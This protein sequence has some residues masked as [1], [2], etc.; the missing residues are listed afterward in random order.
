MALLVFL[1]SDTRLRQ[2]SYTRRPHDDIYIYTQARGTRRAR[3]HRAA[4]TDVGRVLDEA[5][6][7]AQPLDRDA[8]RGHRALCAERRACERPLRGEE[9]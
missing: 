6:L 7:V 9:R 1:D 5:E 4:L 8:R 3:E 2:L